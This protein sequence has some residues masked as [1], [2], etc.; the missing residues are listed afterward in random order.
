MSLKT[1]L[2]VNELPNYYPLKSPLTL[3]FTSAL[4]VLGAEDFKVAQVLSTT[5]SLLCITSLYKV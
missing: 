5:V 3:A 1:A 2:C 4:C